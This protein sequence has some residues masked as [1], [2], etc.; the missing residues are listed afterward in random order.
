MNSRHHSK[1]AYHKGLEDFKVDV[2]LRSQMFCQWKKVRKPIKETE[3][4][5]TS[6]NVSLQSSS[7]VTL[8]N[9]RSLPIG[10]SLAHTWP[11][12]G[13][14]SGQRVV[15]SLLSSRVMILCYPRWQENQ[16]VTPRG[17]KQIVGYYLKNCF[18]NKSERRQPFN[19]TC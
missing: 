7:G 13:F 5:L 4:D 10:I 17:S 19:N 9:I 11:S 18:Q 12:T 15:K 3:I 16:G 6:R 8:P 2:G 1:T 14:R